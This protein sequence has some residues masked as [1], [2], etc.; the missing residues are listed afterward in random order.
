MYA[1]GIS[2]ECMRVLHENLLIPVLMYG[3]ELMVWSEKYRSKV[4]AVQMDNLRG[5][6]GV[7]CGPRP[8]DELLH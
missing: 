7:R 3:S 6:L 8:G 2:L 5:V 4:Q 1:K